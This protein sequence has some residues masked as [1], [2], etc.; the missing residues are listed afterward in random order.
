MIL[1][2]DISAPNFLILIRR[3]R[4]QTQKTTLICCSKR[5]AS[6]RLLYMTCWKVEMGECLK[7]GNV[8]DL[9]PSHSQIEDSQYVVYLWFYRTNKLQREKMCWLLLINAKKVQR[10]FISKWFVKFR[11]SS[12]ND[13]SILMKRRAFC[14][15]VSCKSVRKHDRK[16]RSLGRMWLE[17]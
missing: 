4:N 10:C 8:N 14:K 6:N 2:H 12:F 9:S 1:K 17:C 16:L 5:F 13:Q 3:P 15:D 11:N 7:I